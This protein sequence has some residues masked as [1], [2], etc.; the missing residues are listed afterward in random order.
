VSLFYDSYAAVIVLCDRLEW[1]LHSPGHGDIGASGPNVSPETNRFASGHGEAQLSKRER[2][3]GCFAHHRLA[4]HFKNSS[5]NGAE[6]SIDFL[7]DEALLV[8]D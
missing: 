8:M 3:V 7:K 6:T 5:N 2:L 1:P 4:D